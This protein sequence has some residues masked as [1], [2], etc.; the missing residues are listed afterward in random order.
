[1][2]TE[3]EGYKGSIRN[4]VKPISESKFAG[5]ILKFE[6]PLSGSFTGYTMDNRS[7]YARFK[8][9]VLHWEAAERRFVEKVQHFIPTVTSS[10]TNTYTEYSIDLPVNHR[11]RSGSAQLKINGINQTSAINQT[12]SSSVDFY[13]ADS[14][15]KL[16]IRKPYNTN[17]VLPISGSVFGINLEAGDFITLKYQLENT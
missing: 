8:T 4:V 6:D 16:R 2:L 5:D 1:M 12:D 15:S 13:F 10:S 3:L 17:T 11:I 7:G 9:D 14:Y